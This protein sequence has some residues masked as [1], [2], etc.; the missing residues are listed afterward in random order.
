MGQTF[1][2]LCKFWRI[3]H[4][5]TLVYHKNR[6]T[7]LPGHVSLD[8][9]EFKYRELL[10]WVEG[11]PADQILRNG[12]P[13]HV[14]IFQYAHLPLSLSSSLPSRKKKEKKRKRKR[15]SNPTLS[16]IW[17]HAAILD[18]FRPFLRSQRHERLHLKTFAAHPSSPDAAFNASV[19][20]LK[21]LVIRYRCE[22]ESSAYTLLWQSALI[23]VAN[24]VLH[25]TQN[26]EWR[27]Y[28]LACIYGYE[29]LRRSYRIAEV[30]SRGLLAMTLRDGDISG[31]EA[32]VLLKHIREAEK[33]HAKENVRATFMV[34][35]DLA[36]TDPE[37]ARVE[38]L[39]GRFE[40]IALFRDFT[41]VDDDKVRNFQRMDSEGNYDNA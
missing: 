5:V 25:D 35:L 24:A 14:V 29:G 1:G 11:L 8:F 41:T 17:F 34:D 13:H 2:T 39:A 33:I 36:M 19:R 37:A 30:I 31:T 26:P 15:D 16:S 4:G 38:N 6:Q 7:P 40:D 3:I 18:I 32:R 28:F 20:Q 22:Y 21:Q 9:A 27:F 12:S 23:Y 10:A